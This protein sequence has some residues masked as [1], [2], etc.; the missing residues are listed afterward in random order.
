[1]LTN[2]FFETL[3][4]EEVTLF[5]HSSLNELEMVSVLEDVKYRMATY[6]TFCIWC[7]D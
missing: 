3:L 1:M 7:E 2:K 4:Q 6:D 5:Q